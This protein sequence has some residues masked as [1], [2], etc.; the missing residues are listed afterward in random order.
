MQV[1]CNTRCD[2]HME[3][4]GGSFSLSDGSGFS[5]L[6]SFLAQ[7]LWVNSPKSLWSI[8]FTFISSINK[9]VFCYV[10]LTFVCL[11][12]PLPF[13]LLLVVWS[14]YFLIDKFSLL[15]HWPKGPSCIL[16]VNLQG[17]FC[18][19]YQIFYNS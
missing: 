11:G 15:S 7:S 10:N 2:F 9:P 8:D 18:W 6:P 5:K 13:F 1:F 19:T 17:F 16:S 4:T 3:K 14:V 12:Y